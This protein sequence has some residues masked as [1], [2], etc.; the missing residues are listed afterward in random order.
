MAVSEGPPFHH[1]FSHL[2]EIYKVSSE[3]SASLA[4]IQ[5][6]LF[7][8]APPS[9]QELRA[10][11]TSESAHSQNHNFVPGRRPQPRPQKLWRQ[12]LN[13]AAAILLVCLITGTM[14]SAFLLKKGSPGT[15][16]STLTSYPHSQDVTFL[17]A[18]RLD[19]INDSVYMVNN[20]V[21]W[22]FTNRQSQNTL[23]RSADGD[24]TWK[25]VIPRGL[26]AS[27]IGSVDVFDENMAIIYL[28][29]TDATHF[30]RTIDGG[31][32]WVRLAWPS[33]TTSSQYVSGITV[34]FLDHTY[35]WANL[36]EWAT[37]NQ[38]ATVKKQTLFRTEDGGQSWH[39]VATLPSTNMSA[40]AI[41]FTSAQ[42]GWITTPGPAPTLYLT[43]NGGRS[44]KLQHFPAPQTGSQQLKDLENLTF[45]SESKA[46]I[47]ATFGAESNVSTTYLYT[48]QNEGNSWLRSGPA[49]P[50]GATLR[51]I[52]KTH[53]LE[54]KSLDQG[55]TIKG[56]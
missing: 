13:I 43:T 1:L 8:D 49:L 45:A 19:G 53:V 5:A 17:Q 40:F 23:L 11:T 54:V 20:Q 35:G 51:P 26:P 27:N 48:T 4:R 22:I 50:G 2:Q 3:D 52:D 12:R 55:L 30:Y 31:K 46:S 14:V 25:S 36:A 34:A 42:T 33:T 18:R 37:I 15:T 38:Q 47:L 32:T 9:L 6:R 21:S 29:K 24:K 28:G 39:Q 16:K 10:S 7:K 56:A 44:W 41:T